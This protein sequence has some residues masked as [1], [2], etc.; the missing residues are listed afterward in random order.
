MCSSVVERDGKPS[1]REFESRCI[2]MNNKTEL[3]KAY[4][5]YIRLRD[6]DCNGMIRCISCGRSVPYKDADNGHFFSRSHISTRWDEDNCHAQCRYCNRTLYGNLEHYKANLIKKIGKEAFA[7]L[8]ARHNIT[9]H[10]PTNEEYKVL[11]AG[12]RQC[13][14]KLITIKGI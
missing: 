6:A 3:D 12:Y 10:E 13:C 2:L 8:E 1:M 4:S 7:A 5:L 14:R 9:E 11:I